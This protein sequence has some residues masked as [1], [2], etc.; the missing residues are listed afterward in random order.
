MSSVQL[1]VAAT[2]TLTLTKKIKKE[3]EDIP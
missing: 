3:V 1:Q 2:F